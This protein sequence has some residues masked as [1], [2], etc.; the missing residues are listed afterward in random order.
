MRN[1]LCKMRHVGWPADGCSL[2]ELEPPYV[3]NARA[4]EET[5]SS[6]L[7]PKTAALKTREIERRTEEWCPGADHHN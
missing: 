3:L 2:R 6:T 5:D 1:A 4:A 7:L